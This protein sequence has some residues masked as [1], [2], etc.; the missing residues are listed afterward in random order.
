MLI[1]PNL[2]SANSW[3]RGM[4]KKRARVYDVVFAF[5]LPYAH[6]KGGVVFVD[7]RRVGISYFGFGAPIWRDVHRS[8]NSDFRHN[9]ANVLTA[10]NA[11]VCQQRINDSGDDQHPKCH[12]RIYSAFALYAGVQVAE[13]VVIGIRGVQTNSRT[14]P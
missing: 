6:P 3:R 12:S 1:T 7:L 2:L 4:P 9:I 10:C 13:G 8:L 5:A 11:D 14:K